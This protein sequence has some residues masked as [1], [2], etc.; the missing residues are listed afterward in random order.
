[1]APSS[2]LWLSFLL[3]PRRCRGSGQRVRRGVAGVAGAGGASLDGR[4]APVERPAAFPER[5]PYPPWM[6]TPRPRHPS[7]TRLGRRTV[8]VHADPRGRGPDRGRGGGRG[9]EPRERTW[10]TRGGG[11]GRETEGGAAQRPARRGCGGP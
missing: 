2:E 11:S 9:P 4:G 7:P 5:R 8:R 6:A 1:M 10:R 3:R